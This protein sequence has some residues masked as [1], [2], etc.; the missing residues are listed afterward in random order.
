MPIV[1][2]YSAFEYRVYRVISCSRPR[3][4]APPRAAAAR[5]VLCDLRARSLLSQSHSPPAPDHRQSRE[6]G[7]TPGPFR[8][9]TLAG[10][11]P[12]KT[13]NVG[14]GFSP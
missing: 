1:H 7:C 14:W 6:G 2:I 13:C 9:P 5:V 3:D 11:L 10:R 4:R 12:P 8:T